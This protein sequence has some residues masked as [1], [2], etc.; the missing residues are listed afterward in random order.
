M[1]SL[2]SGGLRVWEQYQ[3]RTMPFLLP[4]GRAAI[5]SD[6]VRVFRLFGLYKPTRTDF[7]KLGIFFVIAHAHL[8]HLQ[9]A[10]VSCE[11]ARTAL[12]LSPTTSILGQ[13]SIKWKWRFATPF[14][15]L[16]SVSEATSD[17]LRIFRCVN[18]ETF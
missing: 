17:F 1:V 4:V 16:Y 6:F 13:Q 10:A 3:Q 8:H 7:Y 2:L 11:R 12:F 9:C 5:N 15:I 18:I 14:L